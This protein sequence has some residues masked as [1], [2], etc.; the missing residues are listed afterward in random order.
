[1]MITFYTSEIRNKKSDDFEIRKKEDG[2]QTKRHYRSN[3]AESS[4]SDSDRGGRDRR[5]RRVSE[6]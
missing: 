5:N 1:M 2:I 3:R 6:I 4:E